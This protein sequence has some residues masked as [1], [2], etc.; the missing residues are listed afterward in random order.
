MN[1]ASL[2]KKHGLG[3]TDRSHSIA[4]WQGRDGCDDGDGRFKGRLDL[5]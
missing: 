4:M 1:T 3:P 2:S 5:K